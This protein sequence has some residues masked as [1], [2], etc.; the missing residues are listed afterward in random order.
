MGIASTTSKFTLPQN[1]LN[2]NT[3]LEYMAIKFPHMDNEIWTQR[4]LAGKVHWHD[5]SLIRPDTRYQAQQ[6]VYYYREVLHEVNIPFDESIVFEDEHLVVAFKPHFLAVIPGGQFVNECLQTRLRI[7]MGL[8]DLQ[9]LHRLDRVTAGLVMFSKKP[10]TR[11]VY[12]QLF[13]Q[14][15]IHKLYQAVAKVNPESDL[16]GQ[17]WQVKN[18]LVA[19]DPKFCMKVVSGQANS[20]SKICCVQQRGD[21]ALFEL[22]PISGKTHQLRVHMASL[23]WPILNDKYYPNLQKE[24]ADDF[25]LPLQLLAKTLRFVDPISGKAREFGWHKGLVL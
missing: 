6:R 15:R 17:Q 10:A 23:T 12:H 4:M 2:V 3:V 11:D 19:G 18:R 9:A 20:Y 16:C 21:K 14:R 1:I 7:K 25:N 8:P 24:S 5:G 22:E 13:A